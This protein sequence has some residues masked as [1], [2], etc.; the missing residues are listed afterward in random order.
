M[1]KITQK[2]FAEIL[3]HAKMGLPNEACGLLGGIAHGENAVV[4]K[5]FTLENTDHSPEHFSM[6]PA[7][8]FAVIKE[9]RSKGQ[10]LIGNF[11]SH[12]SSP[13]RMSEEDKRL[14]F[15]KSIRYLIL[16]LAEASAPVLKCF[17][18]HDKAVVTEEEIEIT[19][20]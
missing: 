3:N 1:L 8:Q 7:Q 19:E 14:A 10:L 11:H 16:S 13:S 2:Q 5:V 4:T 18:I 15:D 20:E 17:H 9:L 6:N 12:P